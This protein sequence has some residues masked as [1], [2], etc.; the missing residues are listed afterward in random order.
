M[1]PQMYDAQADSIK[2]EDI[3][4]NSNNRIV[5][6]RIRTNGKGASSNCLYIQNQYDNLEGEECIDYVPEVVYDM[7]WLGYFISKCDYLKELYIRDFEPPS[8]ASVL[9][10][11]KPFFSGLTNNK[12]LNTLNF[13][14]MDLLDGKIFTMLVPFFK[15]NNNLDVLSL[16]ECILGN[17]GSRLLA[18]A[19]GTCKKIIT[20][21]DATE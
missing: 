7:G 9:D 11:I 19:L 4:T 3:A 18:M 5:L 2:V 12:S 21:C 8:G 15:H 20:K 6:E 16:E 14:G 1:T 17:E 13:F 10:V